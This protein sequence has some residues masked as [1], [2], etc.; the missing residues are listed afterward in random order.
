MAVRAAWAAESTRG[1]SSRLATRRASRPSSPLPHRQPLHGG[2]RPGGHFPPARWDCRDLAALFADLTSRWTPEA[3]P[4]HC[5]PTFLYRRAPSCRAA[6]AAR[7]GLL[8]EPLD[9]RDS[10]ACVDGASASAPSR[11][12]ARR[13]LTPPSSR[14]AAP[15]EYVSF[16]QQIRAPARVMLEPSRPTCATTPVS[17]RRLAAR[18]GD[19][20]PGPSPS[21]FPRA[22]AAHEPAQSHACGSTGAHSGRRGGKLH[23]QPR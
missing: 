16:V 20:S 10:A 13:R 23:A 15:A 12:R 14:V 4:G 5:S 22:L 19:S 21:S 2:W 9:L 1:R 3:R 8:R 7:Y 18:A 17:G 6:A 11:R